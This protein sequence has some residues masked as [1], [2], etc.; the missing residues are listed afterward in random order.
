MARTTIDRLIINS[1]YEEPQ[2]H[3]HYNRETHTFDM[4]LVN[5][6]V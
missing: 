1:P 5:V 3:W 6:G 2:Q 4:V